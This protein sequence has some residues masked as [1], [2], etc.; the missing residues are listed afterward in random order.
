VVR[1]L[2]IN[3]Y[4]SV[5]SNKNGLEAGGCLKVDK[6]RVL[7]FSLNHLWILVIFLFLVFIYECPIRYFLKI[8]CPGCG[9]TRA[10]LAA[11]RLDFKKALGYH[12]LFFAV[13]PTVIYAVWC[14]NLKKRLSEKTEKII[15]TL[16][17]IL[18]VL[19]YVYRLLSGDLTALT[20][21]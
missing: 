21:K 14:T 16:L 17:L 5:K 15:F 3:R 18:F 13:A 12:P 8:P 2:A 20:I 7:K 6:E 11:L 19:V 1:K 9:I 10:H 4:Q